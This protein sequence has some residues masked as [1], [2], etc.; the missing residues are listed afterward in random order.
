MNTHFLV[1]SAIII[2]PVALPVAAGTIQFTGGITEL[3][4]VAEVATQRTLV[5]CS[6]PGEVRELDIGSLSTVRASPWNLADV[7]QTA[8]SQRRDIV[9]TYR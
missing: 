6:R 2:M 5:R 1:I 8:T 4:C 9:I 7:T 3:S